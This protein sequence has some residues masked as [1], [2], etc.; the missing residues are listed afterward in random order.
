MDY[1][2][3]EVDVP[4][5]DVAAFPTVYLLPAAADRAPVAYENAFDL[6]SFSRFLKERGTRAFDVDGLRG[7]GELKDEL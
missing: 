2:K 1:T 7:G 5:L 3:N 6:D 4:G